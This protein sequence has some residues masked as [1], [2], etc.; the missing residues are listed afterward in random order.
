MNNPLPFVYDISH[1]KAI[2]L[3]AD[4]SN[5]SE[6]GKTKKLTHVFGIGSGDPRYFRDILANLEAI[7]L[8]IFN[9]YIQNLIPCYLPEE[10]SKYKDWEIKA[11][12]YLPQLIN[13]LDSIDKKRR[14]PVLVTAERVMK[15]LVVNK[16]PKAKD[17]YQLKTKDLVFKDNKLGRVVI[18]FYRHKNYNIEKEGN[19][20]YRRELVNIFSNS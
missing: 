17:I 12:E 20:G 15:F 2:V 7:N 10:T 5:F 6:R 8:S 14:I 18:P 9:V 1:I 13:D 3:G 11:K 19:E 4:P 16:L